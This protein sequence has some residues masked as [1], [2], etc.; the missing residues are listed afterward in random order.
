MK[1]SVKWLSGLAVLAL[2]AVIV[3]GSPTTTDAAEGTIY[4]TNEWSKL[5]DEPGLNFDDDDYDSASEVWATYAPG[6]S[7]PN[8]LIAS[9]GTTGNDNDADLVKVIFEDE[10]FNIVTCG[11]G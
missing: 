1:L 7:D 6:G 11:S 9:D 5:T 10:E 4:V 8:R 3:A 2:F